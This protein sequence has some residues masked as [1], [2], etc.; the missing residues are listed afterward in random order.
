[1]YGRGFPHNSGII[2]QKIYVSFEWAYIHLY[3]ILSLM[4]RK[5]SLMLYIQLS[6]H[7]KNICWYNY[8]EYRPGNFAFQK[9]CFG[10]NIQYKAGR[11]MY[12]N[13]HKIAHHKTIP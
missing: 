2:I 10:I 4:E 9:A 12:L 7:K 3:L 5:N 1:M 13:A 6:T 8:I 11:D